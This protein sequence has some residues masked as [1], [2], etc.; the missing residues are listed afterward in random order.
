MVLVQVA[1]AQVVTVDGLSFTGPAAVYG[2]T[3][4]GYTTGVVSVGSGGY[5]RVS[6]FS[7]TQ[8]SILSPCVLLAFILGLFLA[9]SFAP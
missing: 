1:K 7:E 2:T 6:C 5:T 3:Y 9:R 4:E 8:T